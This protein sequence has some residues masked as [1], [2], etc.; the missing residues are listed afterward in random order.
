MAELIDRHEFRLALEAEQRIA[1]E[2][3]RREGKERHTPLIT[4]FFEIVYRTLNKAKSVKIESESKSDEVRTTVLVEMPVGFANWWV[5]NRLFLT[6]DDD[7][8]A[9]YEATIAACD[10]ALRAM[11]ST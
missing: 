7:D 6:A 3:F 1:N 10:K 9:P 11:R 2:M 4:V 8:V 5:S